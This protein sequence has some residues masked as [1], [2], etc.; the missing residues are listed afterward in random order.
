VLLLLLLLLGWLPQV[1][2]GVSRRL[3][4]SYCRLCWLLGLSLLLLLLLGLGAR[5]CA[6]DA[7]QYLLQLVAPGSFAVC[8]LRLC[9]LQGMC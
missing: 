6:E 8:T 4:S 3:Q 2:P 7:H 1:A 5:L 9:L